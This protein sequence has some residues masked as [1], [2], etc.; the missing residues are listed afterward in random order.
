MYPLHSR[1]IKYFCFIPP[2]THSSVRLCR[3]HTIQEPR[4]LI[5]HPSNPRLPFQHPYRLTNVPSSL[6]SPSVGRRK[7]AATR[8]ERRGSLGHRAPNS[9]RRVREGPLRHQGNSRAAD[10]AVDGRK[11]PD[12]SVLCGG[13]FADTEDFPTGG[14]GSFR[15]A[16]G[17][18]SF[19]TF[20][21]WDV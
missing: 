11:L 9:R 4:N 2:S 8:R 6:P 14:D 18:V 21:G 12:R 16:D 3:F 17:V 20:G 13:F 7:H 10:D 19:V 5:T 15:S 1:P